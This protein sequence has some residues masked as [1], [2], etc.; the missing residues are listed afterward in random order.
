MTKQWQK[1][2]NSHTYRGFKLRSELAFKHFHFM[3]VLSHNTTEFPPNES[4]LLSY[5]ALESL[6]NC[7]IGGQDSKWTMALQIHS[8]TKAHFTVGIIGLQYQNMTSTIFDRIS[9]CN[10]EGHNVGYIETVHNSQSTD[11]SHL[12]RSTVKRQTASGMW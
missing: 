8:W 4:H 3:R 6:Y 10:R 9:L 12:Y 7:P 11:C 5:L 2:N 1:D